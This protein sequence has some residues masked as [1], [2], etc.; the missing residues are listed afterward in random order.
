MLQGLATEIIDFKRSIN[1]KLWSHIE[2]AI[3]GEDGFRRPVD[4]RREETQKWFGIHASGVTRNTNYPNA[5]L[6]WMLL[7][8]CYGLKNWHRT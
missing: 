7:L 6:S 8:N 3:L 5:I 2:F 4:A 1:F